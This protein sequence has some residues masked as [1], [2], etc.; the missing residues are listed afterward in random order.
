MKLLK[1]I[2]KI[3]RTKKLLFISLVTLLVVL[4]LIPVAILKSTSSST[5]ARLLRENPTVTKLLPVYWKIRK[6]RDI[7]YLPYY[8]KK[9]KL[10]TY[11]L[12]IS[13][14]DRQKMDDSLPTTFRGVLYT[15]KRY[16]PAEFKYGDTTYQVEVRYRGN[17]ANHWNA[18]KKSYLVKF[19]N[20]NLFN[21]TKK[22]SFIIADDRQFVLEQLNQYK[23]DKL[24][25]LYPPSHFGNLQV[26]RKNNGLYYIIE[27]WSQEMLAK[28]EVP[29][30]SNFYSN[31]DPPS[32]KGG[33]YLDVEGHQSWDNLDYWHKKNNDNQFNYEHYTELYQLLDLLNN[34]NQQDF[35]DL[36]FNLVDKDNFYAWQIHQE[37]AH[38]K[39]QVNDVRIYYN[40]AS[41]KFYFIPW[42][43][44]ASPVDAKVNLYSRLA[45]RIFSNPHY[46]HE[47]DTVLYQYLSDQKN[48][49]DDFDFF[50]KTYQEIK[51]A[52]YQDRMKI[53]T[54]K[55]ADNY[56]KRT[57]TNL[58]SNINNLKELF[59]LSEAFVDV[60]VIDD[61]SQKFNNNYLLASFDFNIASP[62]GFFLEDFKVKLDN[63]LELE[64][65]QLYYDV[66]ANHVLD[67]GDQLIDDPKDILLYI[68]TVLDSPVERGELELTKHRIYLV[69]NSISSSHFSNNLKSFDFDLINAMTYKKI[70]DK[71]LDIKLI[72]QKAF[73]HF[74]LINDIQKF[75]SLNPNF[76]VNTS[77]KEIII[78]GN[79]NIHQ[80][81]I[82]PQGYTVKIL[83]GTTLYF[84]PHTSLIS[85]SPVMASNC[86]F[87]AQN[88]DSPWGVFAILNSADQSQFTN[89]RF[90]DGSNDYINGVFFN[91][92][93]SS[94]YSPI[95]IA[96]STFSNAHGDDALNV[97]SAVA[98]IIDSDFSNNSADAIDLDFIKSGSVRNS[99]FK[100][101]GDDSIDL[102]GS[103]VTLQ[104]NTIL[105]S[106]DK[107]ISIG[108]KSID[109]V[110]DDNILFGCNIGV[111]IKDES[112]ITIKN[113]LIED[114][115]IGLHAY[116]KK[117]IFGPSITQVFNTE[118]IDNGQD[119]SEEDDCQIDIR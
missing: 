106:G 42:D 88:S 119:V 15:D 92:M 91:G 70:K 37:L 16:V 69:S 48:I 62:S 55:W 38:S 23:A 93:L 51:P 77:Q 99:T 58:E 21:G 100:D 18:D 68:N 45:Q 78:S 110:I 44:G 66:N 46:L 64:Q 24:G 67:Y 85:Y 34:S 3:I 104:G 114:N 19:N 71:D 81:I 105:N 73:K 61:D 41:G 87:L 35:Y 83:S 75:I 63:D 84:A 10:P 50:D 97:K 28:W 39:H 96:N 102:S 5:R 60:G 94:Y 25:L 116:I 4:I 7:T 86:S 33:F 32:V 103:T 108:E 49:Q 59:E 74:D 118:L 65:Y 13:S 54:N 1:L 47:K 29:D 40:N 89:C 30:E 112:L 31:N 95:E 113:S 82:I 56:I 109:T 90:F 107:C 52:L 20:D 8:F 36:I 43:L 26:D 72:N 101:N 9:N 53:Y 27:G 57:R 98:H 111:E 22:L 2:Y 115:Q 11:E 117:S 76:F 80:T 14:K 6:I 12:S 17:N 79:H